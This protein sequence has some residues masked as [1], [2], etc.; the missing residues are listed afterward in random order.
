MAKAVTEGV[1]HRFR[2]ADDRVNR[3]RDS[4]RR[5]MAPPF[6]LRSDATAMRLGDVTHDGKTEAQTTVYASIRCLGLAEGL[7]YMRQKLRLDPLAVIRH[8][9]LHL[10]R[11]PSRRDL[12]F[13]LAR[14]ELQSIGQQVPDHL[15]QA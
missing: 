9:D 5:A 2:L 4:E 13:P 1:S 6:A 8:V 15:L 7:E 11:C 10:R 3:Q 14:R 12:H